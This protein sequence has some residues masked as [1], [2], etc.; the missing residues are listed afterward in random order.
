MSAFLENL[1]KNHYIRITSSEFK[2]HIALLSYLRLSEHYIIIQSEPLICIEC[3]EIIP[4]DQEI[5]HQNHAHTNSFKI[6]NEVSES[7]LI[8]FARQYGRYY[9][10]DYTI[11][12]LRISEEYMKIIQNDFNLFK[13]S[14]K[15]QQQNQID[16]QQK[17]QQGFTES[18]SKLATSPNFKNTQNQQ[19]QFPKPILKKTVP[20]LRLQHNQDQ[21]QVQPQNI[22]QNKQQQQPQL[23]QRQSN[24]INQAQTNQAFAAHNKLSVPQQ[25]QSLQKPVVQVPNVPL[26]SYD[27]SISG[28]TSLARQVPDKGQQK[29]LI[30]CAK[31]KKQVD[32]KDQIKPGDQ[33]NQKN[34]SKQNDQS[35][36]SQNQQQVQPRKIN[37]QIFEQ[38]ENQDT[39]KELRNALKRGES[40]QNQA[41]NLDGQNRQ[42]EPPN[43]RPRIDNQGFSVGDNSTQ[44]QNQAT[45]QPTSSLQTQTSIITLNK[46][47]QFLR[48][49]AAVFS[50]ND[51]PQITGDQPNLTPLANFQNE[52]QTTENPLTQ[53]TGQS[54]S[55]VDNILQQNK[56]LISLQNESWI[57]NDRQSLLQNVPQLFLNNQ[58]LQQ[59]LL[60][61]NLLQNGES[62]LDTNTNT[63]TENGTPQQQQMRQTQPQKLKVNVARKQWKPPSQ[64]V[65]E[66][67]IGT[68][69]DSDNSSKNKDLQSS[70]K[71]EQEQSVLQNS[72]KSSVA[73]EM[74][75]QE[76]QKA[77]VDQEDEDD[78][79]IEVDDK[80][81]R[82]NSSNLQK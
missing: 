79:I 42:L 52:L 17:Q 28:Q 81:Q 49:N 56:S 20:D 19:K 66:K 32:S 16:T 6:M 11:Q 33:Q 22:Q 25:H 64:E 39:S 77:Q 48:P 27:F 29:T 36:T 68:T 12:K 65:V 15:F 60:T 24:I 46:R 69:T 35:N 13:G 63:L 2:E 30:Q 62:E 31:E 45:L 5:K 4:K 59:N 53:T 44:I 61:E 51:L 7:L 78:E 57:N 40:L 54:N 74:S 38:P 1:D 80:G 26:Q 50:Q 70:T 3:W 23:Q 72:N 67:Q 18:K 82:T 47:Q 58:Q 10:E 8:E 34:L 75:Q 9:D 43:K 21:S 55:M 41:S 76:K 73:Q 71:K 37:L 14:F